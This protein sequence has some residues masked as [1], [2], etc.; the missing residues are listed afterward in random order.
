[1][2]TPEDIKADF[3]IE[4]EFK[5]GSK[6]SPA[7]VFRTMT[8]LIE[9]FQVIDNSLVQSIDVKIEPVLVLED[10]E[11]GSLKAWLRNVLE[12]VDDEALKNIDWKPQVGRYLVKAKYFIVNFL[13]GKTEISDR[14][15]IDDLS[16]NLL[17]AARDTDVLRIPTYTPIPVPEITQ[18]IRRISES[19]SHLDPDDKASYTT[20]D[21]GASFNLEFNFAPE[22]IEELLTKETIIN[23]QEMILKVKKPDYLG[24]SMWDF[25]HEGRT[26]QAKI[27]DQTWLESFQSRQSG[28]RPGDALRVKLQITVHYGYDGEVVGTYFS[29]LEVIDIIPYNP[30]E[31]NAL[32]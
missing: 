9:S 12:V 2:P 7:R 23:E 31:Q 19:L 14:K 4:I 8:D 27:L 30:P 18:S 16:N 22:A 20:A 25:R 5:K 11:A 28:V 1:M 26:I 24:E 21:D 13:E 3:C 29:I 6:S 15:Q 17:K 32:F 10:I